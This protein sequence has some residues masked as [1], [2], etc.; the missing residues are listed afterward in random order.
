MHN[1]VVQ[2]AS[3]CAGKSIIE[4]MPPSV[5]L[6][7]NMICRRCLMVVQGLLDNH[8]LA[9]DKLSFGEVHL[10]QPPSQTQKAA[11]AK[12]LE[13]VGFEL[14]GDRA[15]AL[16]EKIKQLIIGKARNQ[17]TEEESKLKLSAYIAAH[18]HYEYTYLSSLFSSIESRTIENFF[19]EQR[20]EYAKELLV[21]GQMNLSQIALELDYSSTAHLSNQFKKVT[22][23]T[24]SHFKKIGADKRKALDRI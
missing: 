17:L 11:L 6:I 2:T 4:K 1:C 22:G 5:L 21:Y 20:I 15:G 7:K 10:P 13:E 9:Y 24:P 19:I 23:L 18:L 3:D 16:V 12:D 14:I 8:G